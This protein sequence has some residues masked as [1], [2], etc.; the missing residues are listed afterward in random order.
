MIG[1]F[2]SCTGIISDTFG[3]YLLCSDL[4]NCP[5]FKRAQKYKIST[6][7]TCTD[8]WKHLTYWADKSLLW[9]VFA[10]TISCN[11]FK[12]VMTVH[13]RTHDMVAKKLCTHS[14][15]VYTKQNSVHKAKN[16]VQKAKIVVH[17]ARHMIRVPKNSS[18]KPP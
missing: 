7:K 14:K 6:R 16:S 17:T 9:G 18:G 4:T 8:I 1:K 13:G 15:I 2:S 3:K 12:S 10:D 11:E 5:R